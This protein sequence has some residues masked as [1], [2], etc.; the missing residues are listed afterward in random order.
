MS[1]LIP[2]E[3]ILED[4]QNAY[5]YLCKG[6]AKD[7]NW[8]DIQMRWAIK[9]L[10]KNRLSCKDSYAT[11]ILKVLVKV[12]LVSTGHHRKV[13]TG[14]ELDTQ[15]C[16]KVIREFRSDAKERYDRSRHKE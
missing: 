10:I 1:A 13:R 15:A 9:D 16:L 5:T 7:G 4:L 11:L 8:H 12:D 3:K 2:E 14:K 6:M